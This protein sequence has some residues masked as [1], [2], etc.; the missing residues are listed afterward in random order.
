MAGRVLGYDPWDLE[1]ED[2]ERVRSIDGIKTATPSFALWGQTA[3]YGENKYECSVKGLYPEYE[4][5]EHQ[6]MTYDRFIND[7]EI[8]EARKVC[9]IGKR[10]YESLF[11]PGEDPCGKY[12]RVNGI[13]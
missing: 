13:Y 6:E 11:K 2:V 7:V 9:V 10:V 1:M 8:R 3:V 5:I 12:I 4:Q